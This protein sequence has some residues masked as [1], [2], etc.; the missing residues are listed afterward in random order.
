MLILQEAMIC[1]LF[2]G[3]AGNIAYSAAQY[4]NFKWLILIGRL[5]TGLGA[6]NGSLVASYVQAVVDEKDRT[7]MLAKMN[8]VASVGLV[9]GPAFCLLTALCDFQMGVAIVDPL[10]SPGYLMAILNIFLMLFFIFAFK[11]PQ[12]REANHDS[13]FH[14]YKVYAENFFSF[15]F[16]RGIGICFFLTFTNNFALSVLETLTTP[17]T[18]QDFGWG[19]E[20]NAIFFAIVS[21]ESIVIVVLVIIAHRWIDD[22]TLTLVGMIFMGAAEIFQ[23]SEWTGPWSGPDEVPVTLWSFWVATGVLFIGIPIVGASIMS[24]YSKLV[25]SIVGNGRQGFFMGVFLT[26]GAIAR[27]VGPIIG[28]LGLEM[29]DK[30]TVFAINLSVW[31]ANFLLMVVG[32]KTLL[33]QQFSTPIKIKKV[34]DDDDDAMVEKERLLINHDEV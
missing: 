29:Q 18:Q 7:A 15:T 8:G 17:I 12:H 23:T 5:I 20:W 34:N 6:A 4:T 13:E 14:P 16:L 25:E 11:E 9:L 19:T 24:L 10:T 21:A 1:T 32:Y 31:A 30:R 3:A 26:F 28:G 22:R 33:P 2:L 27:I